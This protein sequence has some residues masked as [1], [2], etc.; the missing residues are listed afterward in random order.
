MAHRIGMARI[1]DVSALGVDHQRRV[2]IGIGEHPLVRHRRT[3]AQ[4]DA[5]DASQRGHA[6][7]ARNA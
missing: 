5:K 6:N 2:E 4:H 3:T 7:A 1:K